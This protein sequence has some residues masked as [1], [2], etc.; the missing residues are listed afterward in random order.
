[1]KSPLLGEWEG[2]RTSQKEK[3]PERHS[4]KQKKT[5]KK[6]WQKN[7]SKYHPQICKTN[8]FSRILLIHVTSHHLLTNVPFRSRKIN[9]PTSD[10]KGRQKENY[11]RDLN[12]GNIW[13]AHFWKYGI[14]II[15]YSDA[16]FLLLT[17][18][19]NCG[20]IVRYSD[21]HSN[22]VLYNNDFL[23]FWREAGQVSLFE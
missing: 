2:N 20:Q 4:E 22:N 5:E 12:I 17:G 14:Q 7:I 19:E 3:K 6:K 16:R 15:R 10:L 23:A 21:H 1:M 11:S 8:I 13:I 18:Q 9:E